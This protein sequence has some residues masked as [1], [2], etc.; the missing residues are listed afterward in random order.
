MNLIMFYLVRFVESPAGVATIAVTSLAALGLLVKL[1]LLPLYTRLQRGR[2]LD[3][4]VRARMFDVV[5]A[6]PGIHLSALESTVGIAKG[7]TRHH[8]DKLARHHLVFTVQEGGFTRCYVAGALPP[9]AARQHALL[10]AGSHQR[11]YELYVAR[12]E[13]SLREAA[14]ELGMSAP[15]VHRARRKLVAAGLLSAAV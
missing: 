1:A 10:R 9:E 14:R 11:V 2:L 13:I 7:A 5:R 4:P 12:P 8:L 15:S 6:E 3:H